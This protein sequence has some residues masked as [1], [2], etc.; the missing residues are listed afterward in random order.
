MRVSWA[1]K[2]TYAACLLRQD[3]MIRQNFLLLTQQQININE[4]AVLD[5]GVPIR[6]SNT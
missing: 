1:F 5:V 2:L 3:I 4:V 6:S